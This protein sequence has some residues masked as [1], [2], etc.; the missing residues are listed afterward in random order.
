MQV[1][2]QPQAQ[3]GIGTAALNAA[4]SVDSN[5]QTSAIQYSSGMQTKKTTQ[6]ALHST[7]VQ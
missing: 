4:S 1:L 3:L 6:I 2:P 5:S 7:T